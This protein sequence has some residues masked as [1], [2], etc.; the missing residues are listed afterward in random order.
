MTHTRLP[1]TIHT[2]AALLVKAV[3]GIELKAYHEWA[4]AERDGTQTHGTAQA[5]PRQRSHV[6]AGRIEPVDPVRQRRSRPAY[7][8]AANSSAT[9]AKPSSIQN[10]PPWPHTVWV[11]RASAIAPTTNSTT[12]VSM[13]IFND[14][15]S[16][17][18]TCQHVR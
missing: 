8:G 2:R 6:S 11:S 5:Y 14:L 15:S 9:A 3:N 1:T 10:V 13:M 12:A 18:D 4:K 16:T 7:L 17:R